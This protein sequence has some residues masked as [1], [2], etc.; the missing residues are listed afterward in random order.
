MA[1]IKPRYLIVSKN[2]VAALQRAVNA[3]IEDGW[4]PQGGVSIDQ[5]GS[6]LQAVYLPEKQY[7]GLAQ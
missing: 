2:N 6:F 3:F 7:T 4:E 1:A 5:L